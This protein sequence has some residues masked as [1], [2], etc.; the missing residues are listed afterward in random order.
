MAS[1]PPLPVAQAEV[2]S[3]AAGAPTAAY[4]APAPR[5]A[6]ERA[7]EIKAMGKWHGRH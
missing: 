5:P 2:V 1:A 3:V 6:A 7:A 4:D